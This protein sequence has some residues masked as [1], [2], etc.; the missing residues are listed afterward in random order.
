MHLGLYLDEDRPELS[1]YFALL[2][3]LK[4]RVGCKT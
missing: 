3:P 2:H 1:T 4:V